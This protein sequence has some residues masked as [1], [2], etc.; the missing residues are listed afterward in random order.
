MKNILTLIGLA[1]LL[2][3][4][5]TKTTKEE[6]TTPISYSSFGEKITEDKAISKVEMMEMYKSMKEG[7]TVHVKF[8]SEILDV[9]QK[10]GCWMTLDLDEE[11]EAFVRFA[12]YGFFVPKDAADQNGIVEGKAFVSVTSVDELKHYAKDAG[13]T[14]EEIDEITEPE[15]T[16]S[17]LADGVLIENKAEKPAKTK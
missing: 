11:N 10:K 1:F 7:D 16:Y 5:N 6:T 13:K 14:Q 9:C 4:C 8:Q 3:A 15:Y 17:F 2:A 12:D